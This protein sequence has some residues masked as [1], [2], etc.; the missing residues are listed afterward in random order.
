M[1]SHICLLCNTELLDN[2]ISCSGKCNKFFH[3]TC[4]GM[5][6]TT[7]DVYKK[8][9]GLR[10]QCSDCMNDF[11][12]VWSKLEELSTTVNEIKTMISLGGMV[13]S[14][15]NEVFCINSQTIRPTDNQRVPSTDQQITTKNKRG[16]NKRRQGKRKRIAPSSTPINV[17]VIQTTSSS[18]SQTTIIPS[19]TSTV[20]TES[21]VI[22][23]VS[24]AHQIRAA[25]K[26]TYLW[27]N[28]FHNETTVD[29]VTKLVANVMKVNEPDV[30]CRS[31]KS[32][33]RVYTEFDQ[34]SFRVGLKTTD[35]KDALTTDRWPKGIVCK[36]F[37]SKNSNNRQPVKLG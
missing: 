1:S 26:R 8:V 24:S 19:E 12:S 29:Q 15:I 22:P 17:S 5:T 37:K 9:D 21:T 6:R 11:K 23:N 36:L 27:L 18:Q 28:G 25:E 31:L 33:R 2:L 32:T 16:G 34:I 14:A 7:F 3:Y 13:K 20:S 4:I 30:I 35:V 10:W